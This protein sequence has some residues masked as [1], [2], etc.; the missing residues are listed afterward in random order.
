MIKRDPETHLPYETGGVL[1]GYWADSHIQ[2]VVT[3]FVGAGP[4]A[5]HNEQHLAPDHDFQDA[6]IARLYDESGRQLCYLGDWHTH[7]NGA[8]F[9]SKLDRRTLRLIGRS[10]QARSP[11]PVMIILSGRAFAWSLHGWQLSSI[12]W[13]VFRCSII[14]AIAVKVFPGSTA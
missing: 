8:G 5:L 6:E 10:P 12:G 14:R 11:D 7:P 1:L 9:L 3:H 13:P 4:N 2:A